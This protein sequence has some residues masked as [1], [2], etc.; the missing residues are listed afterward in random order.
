MSANLVF[1]T[2]GVKWFC[3]AAASTSSSATPNLT[4][5]TSLFFSALISY[6]LTFSDSVIG[7]CGLTWLAIS[8][9]FSQTSK[10]VTFVVHTLA[11]KTIG[12]T[13]TASDR[14]IFLCI[15]IP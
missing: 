8:F 4:L 13:N 14:N 5:A 12:E 1:T 10:P 15:L 2:P 9:A 3:F 11:A 6:M 7:K